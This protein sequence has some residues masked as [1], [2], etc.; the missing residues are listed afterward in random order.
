MDEG[1]EGGLKLSKNGERHTK[2]KIWNEQLNVVVSYTT[3]VLKNIHFTTCSVDKFEYFYSIFAW[4][5]ATFVLNT[6][7]NARWHDTLNDINVTK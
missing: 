7:R 2:K 6:H 4:L 5:N 1:V 3:V